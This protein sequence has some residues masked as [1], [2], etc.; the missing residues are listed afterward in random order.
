MLD[1]LQLQSYI[2]EFFSFIFNIPISCCLV[3]FFFLQ[4]TFILISIKNERVK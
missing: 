1:T 3:T 4:I 2:E